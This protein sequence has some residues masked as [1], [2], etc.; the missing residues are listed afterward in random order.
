MDQGNTTASSN[1]WL[2]VAGAEQPAG[3]CAGGGDAQQPGAEQPAGEPVLEDLARRQEEEAGTPPWLL[4]ESLRP[5]LHPFTHYSRLLCFSVDDDD[6][7]F[8][9]RN[10]TRV[11]LCSKQIKDDHRRPPSIGSLAS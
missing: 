9:D 2:A 8:P 3:S 10:G 11:R 4:A 7:F 6:I 5:S 1:N